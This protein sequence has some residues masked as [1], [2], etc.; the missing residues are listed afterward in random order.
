MV[1]FFATSVLPIKHLW[2]DNN[3]LDLEGSGIFYFQMR[4]RAT[5]DFSEDIV[6]FHLTLS[7]HR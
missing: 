4:N 7:Q 3:G 6:P 1:G 5:E 2:N